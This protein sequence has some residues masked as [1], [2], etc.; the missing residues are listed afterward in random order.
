MLC[1]IGVLYVL[2]MTVCIFGMFICVCTY[3]YGWLVEWWG[4]S[5]FRWLYVCVCDVCVCIQKC[6][7]CVLYVLGL[8]YLCM[9]MCMFAY[10]CVCAYVCV[11]AYI[12]CMLSAYVCI[13]VCWFVYMCVWVIVKLCVCMYY[14]GTYGWLDGWMVMGLCIVCG[15]MYMCMHAIMVKCLRM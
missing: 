13:I 10:V 2:C 1:T 4:R 3:M 5:L 8:L 14:V 11:V 9:L 7:L 6:V 12:V 15:R